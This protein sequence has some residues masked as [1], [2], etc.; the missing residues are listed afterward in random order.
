MNSKST[1]GMK[2]C[3]MGSIELQPYLR[4]KTDF[5]MPVSLRRIAVLSSYQLKHSLRIFLLSY[6]RTK[7]CNRK[8]KYVYIYIYNLPG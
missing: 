2:N 4:T 3:L 6:L 8:K 1:N 7:F 5:Y